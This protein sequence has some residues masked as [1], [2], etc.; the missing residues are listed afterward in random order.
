MK[1][2]VTAGVVAALFLT[3]SCSD[4]PFPGYEETDNG[5]YFMIHKEG[6]GK[7][8][9]EKGGAMFVKMK[10][11]D[12]NDSVFYDLNKEAGD[13]S[14]GIMINEPK[15]K[16]DMFD[17]LS[18]FKPGDSV[19]FFVR[20]DSLKKHY[21]NDFNF[22]STHANMPYL[23]FTLSIDSV[24]TKKTAEEK[25]KAAEEE[26]RKRFEVMQK[27]MVIK[28]STRKIVEKVEPGLKKNDSKVAKEYVAKNMAGVTPDNNGIYYKELQPG[29]GPALTPGTNVGLKYTGKYCDGTIFDA[30]TFVEGQELMY[31]PV[32]TGYV[33]KGF[34]DCVMK[35]KLGGK[36][37]FLL[38]P[39]MG[40]ND[41]L[42]RV[43]EVELVE[44][45][46]KMK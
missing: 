1:Q 31:F 18:R 20:M 32:G 19:T 26:Q 6:S 46:S 5:T 23:G 30:N 10:F 29:S 13:E 14:F 36:S 40:Y 16:G 17:M 11:K 12:S 8:A 43:F 3:M 38:P 44:V 22:D 4:S 37:V 45:N 24:Y 41:S 25:Q 27:V 28:D 21:P 2:V 7:E 9:A 33:V 42:S 39:A 34:D 35:M 15:F